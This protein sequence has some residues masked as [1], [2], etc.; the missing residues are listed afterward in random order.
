MPGNDRLRLAMTLVD[1]H[2]TSRTLNVPARSSGRAPFGRAGQV[3]ARVSGRR[4]GGVSTLLE[5]C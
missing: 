2:A 5:R 4:G 3:L 1:M